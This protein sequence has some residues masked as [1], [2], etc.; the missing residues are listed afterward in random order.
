MTAW[1][2]TDAA[3]AVTNLGGVTA[4]GAGNYVVPDGSDGL[5]APSY[6]FTEQQYAGL[7]G[8]TPQ[9]I[10]AAAR[11]AV[12]GMR[13]VASD[14]VELRNRLRALAHTLRPKA[15]MGVLSAVGD[16]GTT[17]TLPCFYRGGLDKGV[18]TGTLY[19]CALQF[20]APSPWW[21]G[22][23]LTVSWGLAGATA[24]FPIF[25]LVLSQS[26]I[27]GQVTVDL[28][29]TDAQTFPVWTVTGPGSQ[30]TLSN[31]YQGV[32]P[33]GTVATVTQSLV[34]APSGGIGDGVNVTI[35]TRQGRQRVVRGDGLNLFGSLS[36]D[37]N[38]FGLVDGVNTVTAVLT[39]AGANSRISL[40]ADRL[41]SGAY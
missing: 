27:S 3:G 14:P 16:D 34:L 25:P 17:R 21:R 8:D 37:P 1:T 10:V 24:F 7:D 12:L 36:S 31:T 13:F 40:A 22:N 26:T 38:L 20:Y 4:W 32:Q 9:Q 5:L 11:Q 29:D 18:Q 15:G 28:S 41:Y 35:D 33:D 19:R 2:W 23:P 30:L 39:N 6:E